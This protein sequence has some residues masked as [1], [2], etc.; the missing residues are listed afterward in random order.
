MAGTV[1]I[2]MA[3]LGAVHTKSDSTAFAHSAATPEAVR[4]QCN[5]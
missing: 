5:R 3:T 1:D 4:S 2:G